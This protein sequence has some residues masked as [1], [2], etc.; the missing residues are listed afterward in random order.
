[1]V[2]DDEEAVA[3]RDNC[4]LLAPTGGQPED[5]ARPRANWITTFPDGFAQRYS[6]QWRGFVLGSTPECAVA[7]F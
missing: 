5:E 7:Y 6:G 1:M 3:D 4:F 2:D